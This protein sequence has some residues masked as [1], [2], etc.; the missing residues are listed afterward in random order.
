M[1]EFQSIL[2]FTFCQKMRFWNISYKWLVN[3][4]LFPPRRTPHVMTSDSES[5]N[6]RLFVN[7]Y[8]YCG[9]KCKKVM[10]LGYFSKMA[11]KTIN[12]FSYASYW[13]FLINLV[14]FWFFCNKITLFLVIMSYLCLMIPML[15]VILMPKLW[16]KYSVAAL[17]PAMML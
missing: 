15:E 11:G 9:K 4:P 3:I 5:L 1:I 12:F 10:F 13:F 17:M 14:S 8:V 2:N 16:Y 6:N 7:S